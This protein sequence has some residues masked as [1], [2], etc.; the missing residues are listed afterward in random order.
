MRIGNES[1]APRLHIGAYSAIVE[2]IGRNPIRAVANADGT[3]NPDPAWVSARI[4]TA[5]MPIIGRVTGDVVMLPQLEAALEEIVTRGLADRINTYDGCYL[6]RF[7][8]RDPSRQ[9]SFH[10]FGTATDLNASTNYRGIPGAIDR[11]VVSISRRGASP[12]VATGTTPTRCPSSW[13]RSC[14]P[15][16]LLERSGGPAADGPR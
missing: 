1:D 12:G 5:E 3:V 4:R 8:A 16:D 14:R 7:I 9:L 11:T 2:R 10:T 6:P 13:P 15:A